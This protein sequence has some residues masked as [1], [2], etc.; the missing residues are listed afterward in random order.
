MKNYN[1][2]IDLIILFGVTYVKSRDWFPLNLNANEF[3]LAQPAKVY[4]TVDP[5]G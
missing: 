2:A 3:A 5:V 1:F 4:E